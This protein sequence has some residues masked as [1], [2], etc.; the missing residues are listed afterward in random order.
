MLGERLSH[1]RITGRLGAGG[2]GV[3]YEAQDVTLGRLVAI[4]V[5]PPGLLAD[6]ATLLRFQREARAASALNHPHICIVHELGE[7]EDRPFIVMERLQGRTLKHALRAG[8]LDCAML[9]DLAWQIADA[10]D[11]AHRAGIVHRDLKPDNIFVT[12][13]QVVKLLDFGLAKLVA[14]HAAANAEEAASAATLEEPITEIG[15]AMGTPLYMSPEQ[16]RGEDVDCRTDLFSFGAVLYEMATGRRAFAGATSEAVRPGMPAPPS[17][18]VAGLPAGFDALVAKALEKDRALR[19]QTAADLKADLARLRRDS[20]A[21]LA[22]L[23]PAAAVRPPDEGAGASAARRR[24]LPRW[25]WA[26]G[27][28]ILVT[29]G[30]ALWT[31]RAAS[32]APRHS[33]GPRFSSLAVLPLENLARDAEQQY[34][35]DGMTEALITNLS[36]I[37]SLRVI[38]RTSSQ[39]VREVPG[40]RLPEIARLLNVDAVVEGTV[41][42]SG[43]RVRIYARLIATADDQTVWA[44]AYERDFQNVLG[45]QADVAAA[46][47]QEIGGRLTGGPAHAAASRPVDSKAYELYLKGRYFWNMYTEEG[48]NKAID[49]FKQAIRVDGRYAP[50]WAGL[51]DSVPTSSR[52]PSCPRTR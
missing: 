27:A 7:H 18:E 16:M 25:S 5:L 44:N 10:L 1:Y 40:R 49:Y 35:A 3:V 29:A 30:I 28:A 38:S 43:D 19:Y 46:I 15:R 23:D 24:V 33:G 51:A 39:H 31:G 34:F 14:G 47:A 8:P 20:E 9:L 22:V 17:A 41:I 45:L 50:A 13:Q 48:W 42:R 32:V 4:K 2:M 11:A 52:R 36:G 21:A 37:P 6:R 12:Q 26:A